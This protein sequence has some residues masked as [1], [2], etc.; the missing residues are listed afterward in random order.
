MLKVTGPGSKYLQLY[1]IIWSKVLRVSR[2]S[3]SVSVLT[4]SANQ[5]LRI[6]LK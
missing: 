3:F 5:Y 4:Y 1:F 2:I 6:K